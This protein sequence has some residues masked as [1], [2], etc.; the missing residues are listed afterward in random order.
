MILY[1]GTVIQA[2]LNKCNK[3]KGQVAAVY[4]AAAAAAAVWSML[5]PCTAVF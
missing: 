2:G 5:R 1:A 4:L 3:Q